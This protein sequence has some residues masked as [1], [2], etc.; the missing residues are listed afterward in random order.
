MAYIKLYNIL[1][2][3]L[4]FQLEDILKHSWVNMYVYNYFIL[5]YLA[6]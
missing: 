3:V 5:S 4:S 1:C 2:F 6:I